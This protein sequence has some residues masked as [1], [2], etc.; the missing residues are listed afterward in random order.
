MKDLI[1][2]LR[3]NKADEALFISHAIDEIREEVKSKDM[4]I[5]AAAIL[6]LV[7]VCYLTGIVYMLIQWH[8]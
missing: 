6:K 5:K 8:S 2:G 1:R 7:Y 4:D 3:A